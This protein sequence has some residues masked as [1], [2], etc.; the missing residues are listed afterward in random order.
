MKLRPSLILEPRDVTQFRNVLSSSRLCQNKL[1][2]IGSCPLHV[3]YGCETR[4]LS[5]A[6]QIY[7]HGVKTTVFTVAVVIT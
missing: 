4:F 1:E 2:S 3:L 6:E 5:K 7:I